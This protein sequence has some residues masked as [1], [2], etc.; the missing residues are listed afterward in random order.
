MTKVNFRRY[1][2][3]TE[4][5]TKDIIDGSFIVTKDGANYVDFGEERVPIG[6]TP[7]TEM[8]DTSENSVQNKVIKSYVDNQKVNVKTTKTESDIDTY[9]CNYVN[10][11]DDI[12]KVVNLFGDIMGSD[13]TYNV[14]CYSRVTATKISADGIWKFEIQGKISRD[15]SVAAG[16]YTWGVK[17]EKISALLNDKIGKQVQLYDDTILNSSWFACRP[18]GT[19]NVPYTDRMDYGTRFENNNNNLVPARYYT[20]LGNSGGWGL[21]SFAN[22]SYFEATIYLKEV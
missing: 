8:S 12:G 13:G 1:N 2:T 16:Y 11:F 5:L 4:A 6:G 7:D 18:N 10:K 22:D 17:V 14:S 20:T 3:K 21:D 19:T 15:E 9:S